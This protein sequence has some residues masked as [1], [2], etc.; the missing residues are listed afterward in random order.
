[1][2]RDNIFNVKFCVAQVFF[3]NNVSVF[4]ENPSSPPYLKLLMNTVS[5]VCGINAK[6]DLV[7]VTRR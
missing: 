6:A 5:K 7:R 4:K 3:V 2:Q 1:M